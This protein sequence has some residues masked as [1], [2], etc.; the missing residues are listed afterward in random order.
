MAGRKL[1]HAGL[2]PSSLL[3]QCHGRGTDSREEPISHRVTDNIVK[4]HHT[5]PL[6]DWTRGKKKIHQP[7]KK[8]Q[9]NKNPPQNPWKKNGLPSLRDALLGGHETPGKLSKSDLSFYRKVHRWCKQPLTI[10]SQETTR[11][12]LSSSFLSS[13]LV[14]AS[15]SR[16]QR[17]I[18]KGFLIKWLINRSGFTSNLSKDISFPRG[19]YSPVHVQGV[20]RARTNSYFAYRELLWRTFY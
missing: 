17:G 14:L 16:E 9:T 12:L 2:S 19:H 3:L 8:I 20:L 4:I 5:L 6:T 1:Q 18:K 15:A 13:R 7:T 10:S 11:N